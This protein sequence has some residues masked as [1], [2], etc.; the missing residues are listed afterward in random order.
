MRLPILVP[1]N[2]SR[3]SDK[4]NT[5][6]L[7]ICSSP[8]TGFR[9]LAE[10]LPHLLVSKHYFGQVQSPLVAGERELQYYIP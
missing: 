4:A 2:L 6:Y 10:R 9:S 8:W 1:S 7:L 3:F 5:Y